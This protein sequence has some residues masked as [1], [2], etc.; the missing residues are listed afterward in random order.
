MH[1]H[2]QMQETH[3][4][5]L[6]V[7]VADDDLIPHAAAHLALV[8]HAGD[9]VLDAA[10]VLERAEPLDELGA[11]RGARFGLVEQR[12]A[13][14]YLIAD[15]LEVE[16]NL[17]VIVRAVDRVD[18]DGVVRPHF[19]GVLG[20]FDGFLDVDVRG[21]GDGLRAAAAL[22]ADDVLH[23]LSLLGRERPV[24]AHQP[25]AE[26]PVDL[27]VVD[28][29]ADDL[30]KALLVQLTLGREG[31]REGG[32]DSR[33]VLAAI[34]FRFRFRVFHRVLLFL[35]TMRNQRTNRM[36]GYLAPALHFPEYLSIIHQNHAGGASIP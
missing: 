19:L 11:E 34:C 32:P 10:D 24:L 18:H 35:K 16:E 30:A 28:A 20:E 7:R 17:V 8:R 3:E 27:E 1:L 14:V 25:V 12:E 9:G 5:V 2:I 26:K 21:V 29:G 4:E 15:G 23:A 13:D 36:A 31:R 33:H 6:L 22:L